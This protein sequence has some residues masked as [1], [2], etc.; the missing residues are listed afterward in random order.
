MRDRNLRP[1]L[2]FIALQDI[3]PHNAAS[4]SGTIARA[5][6]AAGIIGGRL[7]DRRLKNDPS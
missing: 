4:H 2:D 5:S 7:E 1:L 6:N 3:F